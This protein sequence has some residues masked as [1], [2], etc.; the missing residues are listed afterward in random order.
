MVGSVAA[1]FA[2]VLGRILMYPQPSHVGY[3]ISICNLTVISCYANIRYSITRLG[4]IYPT[5]WIL[6]SSSSLILN[7]AWPFWD[8]SKTQS[9]KLNLRSSIVLICSTKIGPFAAHHYLVS[10]NGWSIEIM[11]KIN[12]IK[13]NCYSKHAATHISSQ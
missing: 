3:L 11:N 13:T 5:R 2:I 7:Q 12:T 10:L 4:S 6:M 8:S 1:V 9:R